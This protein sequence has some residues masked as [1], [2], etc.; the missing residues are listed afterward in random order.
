M[1]R[2]KMPS[3]DALARGN[4]LSEIREINKFLF[5]IIMFRLIPMS[6]LLK[7][8]VGYDQRAKDFL[9]ENSS[10]AMLRLF[11]GDKEIRALG[12]AAGSGSDQTGL[13][14][15]ASLAAD[16]AVDSF[17]VPLETEMDW[18]EWTEFARVASCRLHYC[19]V[20]S[21]TI[22]EFCDLAGECPRA[23]VELIERCVT[24]V[25]KADP[26]AISLAGGELAKALPALASE[27]RWMV[28][29]KYVFLRNAT[30]AREQG[31]GIEQQCFCAR[32][33]FWTCIGN[34]FI[35]GSG[36]HAHLSGPEQEDALW[37][38]SKRSSLQ[39]TM[40]PVVPDLYSIFIRERGNKLL[41]KL[42]FDA[43][44]S[45]AITDTEGVRFVP[46]RPLGPVAWNDCIKRFAK[47]E[48]IRITSTGKILYGRPGKKEFEMCLKGKR[49]CP[50]LTLKFLSDSQVMNRWFLDAFDCDPSFANMLTAYILPE[51]GF[52]DVDFN[53]TGRKDSTRFPNFRETEE[54][55][56]PGRFEISTRNF[57]DFL[58]HSGNDKPGDYRAR[59]ISMYFDRNLIKYR[60]HKEGEKALSPET[61]R[62]LNEKYCRYQRLCGRKAADR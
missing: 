4:R 12:N 20:I 55:H 8:F 37:R 36:D 46:P 19:A 33:G 45:S 51:C 11:Y 25:M 43:I 5:L 41:D 47:F 31:K 44:F 29:L 48:K 14:V 17:P 52:F 10:G 16:A 24:A 27:D 60:V 50:D 6:S 23:P 49:R 54:E 58:L 2:T 32:K 13:S 59:N 22:G 1:T 40:R 28:I 18:E 53:P 26:G 3:F 9:T 7:N 34:R 38:A 42:E 30:L 35:E 62:R 61:E 21:N 39:L 56:T 15:P 57:L